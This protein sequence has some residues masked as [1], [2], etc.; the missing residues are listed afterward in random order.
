MWFYRKSACV[1]SWPSSLKLFIN[2]DVCV[3]VSHDGTHSVSVRLSVQIPGYLAP[4]VPREGCLLGCSFF[5]ADYPSIVTPSLINAWVRVIREH[6]GQV[7][8]DPSQQQRQQ[9]SKLDD[10]GERFGWIYR[11]WHNP[12]PVNEFQVPFAPISVCHCLFLSL[13]CLPICLPFRLSFHLSLWLP[14][15]ASFVCFHL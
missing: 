6:G 10:N 13:S 9:S 12:G 11:A 7:K 15:F 8:L 4:S 14:F 3:C 5:I 1:K 2:T